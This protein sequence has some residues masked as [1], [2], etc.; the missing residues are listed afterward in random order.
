MYRILPRPGTESHRKILTLLLAH[1][2]LSNA[3]SH[4]YTLHQWGQRYSERT[5]FNLLSHM[6]A[7]H[8]RDTYCASATQNIHTNAS[9]SLFALLYFCPKFLSLFGLSLTLSIPSLFLLP[10]QDCIFI[11]N[12]LTT[13]FCDLRRLRRRRVVW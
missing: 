7:T 6:P 11:L 13:H 2:L 10:W 9:S 1:S 8:A 5:H 12:Q 4:K 3:S